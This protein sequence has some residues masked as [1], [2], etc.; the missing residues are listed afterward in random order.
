MIDLIVDNIEN[1]GKVYDEVRAV[2][3]DYHHT[4]K[5]SLRLVQDHFLMCFQMQEVKRDPLCIL[6]YLAYGNFQESIRKAA[7]ST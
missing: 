6:D 3:S 2:A 4:S 1:P 7:N 5:R